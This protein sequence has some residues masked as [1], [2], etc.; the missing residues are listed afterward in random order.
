LMVVF[1]C[2]RGYSLYVVSEPDTTSRGQM[3]EF[4]TYEQIGAMPHYRSINDMRNGM[5]MNS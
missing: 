4:I 2:T 1:G 5:V 3:R